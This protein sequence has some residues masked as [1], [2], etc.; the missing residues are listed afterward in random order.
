MKGVGGHC[1]CCGACWEK[2]NARTNGMSGNVKTMGGEKLLI[3][4]QS[5]H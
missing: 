2:V 3:A 4:L 1:L 5:S